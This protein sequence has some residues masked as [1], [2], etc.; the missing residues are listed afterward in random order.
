MVKLVFK[1]IFHP[2]IILYEFQDFFTGGNIKG[3]NTKKALTNPVLNDGREWLLAH[4][5][6]HLFH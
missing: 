4:L 1:N 2:Y 3:M 6:S 5:T